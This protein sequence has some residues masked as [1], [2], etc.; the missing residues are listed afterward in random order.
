LKIHLLSDLHLE[1]AFF[2]PPVN[3]ADI[4]V[5]AGDIGVGTQGVQ[6]AKDF[7]DVP[8][9]YVAGNHEYHDPHLPMAEHK[10]LIQE[11]CAGSN[12][13]FLDNDVAM[14][15]GVRFIGSTLWAD[16]KRAPDAL[17]CDLDSI[18]VKYE[19]TKTVDG[20]IH[21]NEA[22]NQSLFEK[23][24]YRLASVIAKPF[25]QHELSKTVSALQPFSE[26][27]AQSLFEKNKAWLK[28]E[29]AKP[30]DGKTV[31]VTHH[32]PSLGSLHAQ[33][34]DNPWNPCF[35][36][37]LEY[38][39]GDGVDLWMHGHTHNNF[40]Y[41][42]HGT[43][44]VCNPRGYPNPLGN[45]ENMMFNPDLMVQ[46][47]VIDEKRVDDTGSITMA[48][49]N[50]KPETI[51]KQ[52][53][54]HRQPGQHRMPPVHSDGGTPYV[55]LSDIPE[56][57]RPYMSAML[58][59]AACPIPEGLPIGDYAFYAQ[60]YEHWHDWRIVQGDDWREKAKGEQW[61]AFVYAR[62]ADP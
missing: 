2:M 19:V 21:F 35:I 11:T 51:G 36:S 15:E 40:D 44:V 41:R 27:Y 12:V 48:C 10:A 3:S 7:F 47:E 9:I 37:D 45:W 46:L 8:V 57:E 1:R 23:N 6:W 22:Y 42:V 32:A 49:E 25:E 24:K 39:M 61:Y 17:F 31:V 20:L 62:A 53:T 30:F 18:V 16:L 38:L 28:N 34:A 4:V 60:D 26:T 5:L 52:A 13:H 58:Y 54:E 14:I 50:D 56:C 43:R 59:G 29:L 55:L 33:Y